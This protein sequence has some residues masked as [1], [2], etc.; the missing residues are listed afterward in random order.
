MIHSLRLTIIT[1]HYVC[2]I[3]SVAQILFPTP[4]DARDSCYQNTSGQDGGCIPLHEVWGDSQSLV[5]FA[6]FQVRRSGDEGK[7]SK[8]MGKRN[9]F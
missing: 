8:R 4:F 7:C 1:F 6:Q 9:A 3:C 5:L 2:S